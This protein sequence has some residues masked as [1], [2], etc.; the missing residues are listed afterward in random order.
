MLCMDNKKD[1][2]AKSVTDIKKRAGHHFSLKKGRASPKG[3]EHGLGRKLV[4][5]TSATSSSQSLMILSEC[6][7]EAG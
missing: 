3:A 4:R 7:Y 1:K 5:D 2:T 6:V